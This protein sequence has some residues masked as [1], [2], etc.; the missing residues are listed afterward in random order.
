MKASVVFAI[1]AISLSTFVSC[2]S[3]NSRGGGGGAFSDSKPVRDLD[4]GVVRDPNN[5]AGQTLEDRREID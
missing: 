2:E 3:T 1:V 5:P 4:I